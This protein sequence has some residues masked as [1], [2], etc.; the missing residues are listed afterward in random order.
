MSTE[1][2]LSLAGVVLLPWAVA[3]LLLIAI[4]FLALLPHGYTQQLR[5]RLA[6][7]V[8]WQ[9][10]KGSKISAKAHGWLWDEGNG[11]QDQ[12]QKRPGPHEE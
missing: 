5:H 9:W 3:L 12:A 1:L 6:D 10:V 4:G 7:G 8:L 11:G 2:C